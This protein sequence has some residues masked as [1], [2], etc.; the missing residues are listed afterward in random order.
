MT[1][2]TPDY[3]LSKWVTRVWATDRRYYIGE[4]KQD[5]FGSWVLH[6]RWGSNFSRRGNGQMVSARDYDS[7]LKMLDGVAK[8][9]KAR[10][11]RTM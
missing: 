4:V 9:R 6:K 5:I 10:H 7:A 3:E 8:E 2:H 1:K 11:Y